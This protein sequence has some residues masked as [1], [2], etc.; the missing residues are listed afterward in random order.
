MSSFSFLLSFSCLFVVATSKYYVDFQLGNDKDNKDCHLYL[1]C[2]S[3]D[4]VMALIDPNN[5]KK[6]EIYINGSFSSA[7][8]IIINKNVDIKALSEFSKPVIKC[9]DDGSP[10]QD[11][12]FGV[13]IGQGVRKARISGVEIRNCNYG[14]K[15]H[16]QDPEASVALSGVNLHHNTQGVNILQSNLSISDSNIHDNGWSCCEKHCNEAGSGIFSY[17]ARLDIV[18]T[19]FFNNT[20]CGSSNYGGGA[21]SSYESEVNITGSVINS[22][23]GGKDGGGL[24]FRGSF[25]ELENSLVYDNSAGGSGGGIFVTGGKISISETSVRTN[26]ASEN[27]GGG[28]FEKTRLR[29]MSSEF[30]TNKAKCGGGIYILQG[31]TDFCG[32]AK[33]SCEVYIFDNYAECSAGLHLGQASVKINRTTVTNNHQK[34]MDNEERFIS[35]GEIEREASNVNKDLYCGSAV[36]IAESN[37]HSHHF[38]IRLN[39]ASLDPFQGREKGHVYFMKSTIEMEGSEI[40]NSESGSEIICK[41]SSASVNGSSVPSM[42]SIDCKL[43][44]FKMN[45][46]ISCEFDISSTTAPVVPSL[47]IPAS[48]NLRRHT[49]EVGLEAHL[50]FF[51]PTPATG[52]RSKTLQHAQVSI[53]ELKSNRTVK[54]FT[55]RQSENG[56]LQVNIACEEVG[57][58]EVRLML[59]GDD[60]EGSPVLLH[61][62]DTELLMISYIVFLVSLVAFVILFVVGM[63]LKRVHNI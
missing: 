2:K 26:N 31:S 34:Q 13:F 15:I 60:V 28:Y 18:N 20:S 7:M 9:V 53:R 8:G 19:N 38:V 61:V 32:D 41:Y 14:I 42:K 54:D 39:S 56:V 47:P 23:S 4:H 48:S 57:D 40:S 46:E 25:V 62:E 24:F 44:N 55:V 49:V 11:S 59:D 50:N 6:T 12:S 52:K 5:D 17:Q 1:P 58:Y 21:I 45:G 35:R 10:N 43:C 37:L 36:T 22:N 33:K 63:V 51:P 3:V 16:T 27:G 29:V 30:I